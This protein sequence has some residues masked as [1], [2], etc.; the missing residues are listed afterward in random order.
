MFITS[1][2]FPLLSLFGPVFMKFSVLDSLNSNLYVMMGDEEEQFTLLYFIW[3]FYIVKNTILT[4]NCL[5]MITQMLFQTMCLEDQ[6]L[7]GKKHLLHFH[8]NYKKIIQMGYIEIIMD[9]RLARFSISTTS[10]YTLRR[11]IYRKS[12][13]LK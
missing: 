9:N 8:L 5:T 10:F 7:E 13:E 1:Q 2:S 4:P 12:H 3:K 11:K 6:I